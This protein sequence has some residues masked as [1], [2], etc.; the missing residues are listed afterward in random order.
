MYNYDY[1]MNDLNPFK[2][3][4]ISNVERNNM[5]NNDSSLFSPTM[6]YNN[7]NLF[8][9]LYQQYKD[10]KPVNLTANNEKDKLLLEL[11]RFSFAAHELNLYLDVYPDDVSMITL[12]NDYREKANALEKEYES[13][14]GPLSINSSSLKQTPF[15]WATEDWPWEGD[16]YV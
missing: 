5:T 2:E 1:F 6:A 7:G 14:Y 16:S 8:S 11:D 3:A 12:F 9:N 4:I 15:V 10:Y 13:K